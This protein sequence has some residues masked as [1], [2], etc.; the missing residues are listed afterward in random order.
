MIKIR[1]PAIMPEIAIP[2]M[3]E[4]W[5]YVAC[6]D[7]KRFS[8]FGLVQRTSPR[9]LPWRFG[10]RNNPIN[11]GLFVPIT[12]AAE[13]AIYGYLATLDEQCLQ[14]SFAK[15]HQGVVLSLIHI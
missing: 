1:R 8:A 6:L 13:F 11:I 5:A 9:W 14:I 12:F 7:V 4:F 2:R 15:H 3:H 10:A